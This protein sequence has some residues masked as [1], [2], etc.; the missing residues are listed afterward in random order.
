[1]ILLRE[2]QLSVLSLKELTE[3]AKS[4][5]IKFNLFYI[6][7]LPPTSEIKEWVIWHFLSLKRCMTELH[8]CKPCKNDEI[9]SCVNFIIGLNDEES[10]LFDKKSQMKFYDNIRRLSNYFP[11]DAQ[12]LNY[13]ID[14]IISERIKLPFNANYESYFKNKQKEETK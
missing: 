8:M 3:K 11:T 14:E 12:R 10:K 9:Y 2:K 5:L 7:P 1:M 4:N 6:E 13:C